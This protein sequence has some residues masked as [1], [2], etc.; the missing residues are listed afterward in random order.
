MKLFI[1]INLLIV[2]C[3]MSWIAQAAAYKCTD[4]TGQVSYQAIPCQRNAKQSILKTEKDF[5]GPI[6]TWNR[7]GDAL[8]RGDK[9]AALRELRKDAGEIFSPRFDALLSKTNTF[10]I[11]QLG[12]ISSIVISGDSLAE[13][14]LLRKNPTGNPKV[15][16]VGMMR[17]RHGRWLIVSM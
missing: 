17:D 5:N 13:M 1:Q 2:T 8:K 7:L 3:V 12:I 6:E 14:T 9:L 15:F 10:D 4:A 16:T 11:S